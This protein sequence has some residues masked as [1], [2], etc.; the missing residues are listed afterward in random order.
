[1]TPHDEVRERIKLAFSALHSGNAA[2]ARTL[3]EGLARAVEDNVSVWMGLA[4]AYRSLSMSD[5]ALTAVERALIL[6]PRN[7]SINLLKA[8]ILNEHGAGKEAASFYQ[9]ALSVAPP[10]HEQ[11]PA[12]QTE[13]ARAAQA[14]RHAAQAYETRLRQALT[15][16]RFLGKDASPAHEQAVDILFSKRKIFLQEP[17]FF[18]FPGLPQRQF[19]ERSEFPWVSELEALTAEIATEAS[20]LL[21]E[22]ASNF[23]PYLHS[24]WPGPQIERPN[25]FD[26]I[27]WSAFFLIEKGEVVEANARRCPHTMEALKQVPLCRV[28]NKMPSVLFSLLRPG[29]RIEPHNGLFNTR[30][31]CHLPLVVPD[32]CWLRVGNERRQWRKAEVT[33]FDDSIE[34]EAANESD[35]PR[36]VLLFDI[37]RPE[38]TEQD[39]RF[40]RSL[41]S[42]IDSGS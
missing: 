30:L 17:Q 23:R 32:S 10:A 36:I 29:T 9:A 2:E 35:S 12:M 19:Y 31:I 8:D 39:Q 34:H 13:V 28:T 11:S 37:W 3:L 7:F 25:L 27:D 22:D 6:Q 20:A 33:I 4:V 21:N 14:I 26:S 18:Y 15:Y 40:I 1:M 38:L 41:F 5:K 24:K 42:V 16:Q